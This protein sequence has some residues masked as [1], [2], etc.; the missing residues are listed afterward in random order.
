MAACVKPDNTWHLYRSMITEFNHAPNSNLEWITT[1]L[2]SDQF[3]LQPSAKATLAGRP[4]ELGISPKEYAKEHRRSNLKSK[5]ARAKEESDLKKMYDETEIIHYVWLL[6][7]VVDE[8][9]P[10]LPTVD[11]L[12]RYLEFGISEE[13][14]NEVYHT[15]IVITG[16]S[17]M[18]LDYKVDHLTIGYVMCDRLDSSLYLQNTHTDY[19]NVDGVVVSRAILYRASDLKPMLKH[20]PPSTE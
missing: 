18:E 15:G 16:V 7:Q 11:L 14:V 2:F 3:N 8:T 4:L 12:F 1:T 5:E 6:Q 20:M 9:W 17:F 10:K 13:Q 19:D